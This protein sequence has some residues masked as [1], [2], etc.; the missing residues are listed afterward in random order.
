MRELAMRGPPYSPAERRDL[1]AYCETDVVALAYLLDPL[2]AAAGLF[3]RR[4]LS[5]AVQ[6]G[7]YMSALASVEATGV[8]IAVGLSAPNG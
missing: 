8:P 5:Q 4:T 6:R 3:D 7:R 2:A 1:L